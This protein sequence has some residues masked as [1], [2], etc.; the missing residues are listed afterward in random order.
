MGPVLM[1]AAPVAPRPEVPEK[2]IVPTVTVNI[3]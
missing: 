3:G 1:F 2:L